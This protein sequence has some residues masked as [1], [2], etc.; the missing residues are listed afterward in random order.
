MLS[1][2]QIISGSY[3]LLRASFLDAINIRPSFKDRGLC[4]AIV[5]HA[6]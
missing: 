5:E 3:H 2:S 4:A 1:A 6:A